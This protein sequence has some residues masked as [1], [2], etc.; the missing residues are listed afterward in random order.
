MQGRAARPPGGFAARPPVRGKP[1][2]LGLILTTVLLFLLA[3][4]AAWSSY[5]LGAWNF[6]EEPVQTVAVD[7]PPPDSGPA[8]PDAAGNTAHRASTPPSSPP[9]PTYVPSM[10][11][12]V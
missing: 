12:T 7:P 1:R 9:T 11:L 3:M 10:P 5:S 4:I 8:V 6:G 2:Y